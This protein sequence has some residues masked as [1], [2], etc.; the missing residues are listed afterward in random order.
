MI[1]CT[2][3][4][5]VFD[6]YRNHIG[7]T[8]TFLHRLKK[9]AAIIFFCFVERICFR[10]FVP[11][12]LILH[13]ISQ[14]ES[15][16]HAH[17]II[18]ERGRPLCNILHAQ[19]LYRFSLVA[20]KSRILKMLSIDYFAWMPSLSFKEIWAATFSF[21][22]TC[23]YSSMFKLEVEVVAGIAGNLR[24]SFPQRSGSVGM[25]PVHR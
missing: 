15:R 25:L 3:V 7:N 14:H 6:G 23:T 19:I 11:A 13:F 4:L 9:K 22:R 24:S 8:S 12:H 17:L 16:L 1:F 21:W 18:H 20:L 2:S 5:E 10:K